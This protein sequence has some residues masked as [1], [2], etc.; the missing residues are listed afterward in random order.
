MKSLFDKLIKPNL[1]IVGE[2][3][4]S[5][6]AKRKASPTG[7]TD[8]FPVGESGYVAAAFSGVPSNLNSSGYYEVNSINIGITDLSTAVELI[9][10]S[11]SDSDFNSYQNI[12]VVSLDGLFVPYST[13][14]NHLLLPHFEDPT[15]SGITSRT[16]NPFD[17]NGTLS[18]G[19]LPSGYPSGIEGAWLASGH[20]INLATSSD[21]S[22]T[23]IT[24]L[25]FEKDYWTRGKVSVEDIRS[26]A[27]RSPIILSGWGFDTNGLPVPSGQSGIFH[28]EAFYNP[29]LWKTGPVDLRWDDDRKVWSASN[30]QLSHGIVIGRCND[31]CNTYLV[32]RIKRT[33]NIDCSSSG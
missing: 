27:L 21:S 6:R 33:M 20:N 30:V 1:V 7:P 26:I 5:I 16:L 8:I 22:E 13:D 19:T 29:N 24:D 10:N 17:P 28:P 15:V 18:S 2:V 23:E 31:A 11:A 25:S 3:I 9:R 14:P 12:S 32:R 4:S